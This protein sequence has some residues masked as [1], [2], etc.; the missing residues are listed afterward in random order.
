MQLGPVKVVPFA[1]GEFAHWG[2][3]LDG[4]S[5]DRTY[6]N[7]GVRASIPFW[8]VYPEVH[9]TLF[10]LNGLA[11]KVVF[12]AE[13]SYADANANFDEFPLYDPLDDTSLYEFRRR[14]FNTTLPPNIDSPKFDPRTYAIRSG[15]QG[16]VT[17]PSTEM[18]DDLLAARFGM[19]NRW[20]TKRGGPGRQHIVDWLTIDTNV[21]LFP[22]PD[23]DNFGQEL[24]LFDYDLRW[25]LGDRFTVLSDGAAD[26]FGSGLITAAGGILINRPSRWNGYI[27]VRTINGPVSSNAIIGSYSYRL[28]EKWLTSGSATFDLASVGNIGQTFSM[29]RIGESMLFSVGFNVDKSKNNVG[30]TFSIE[31][32]FLPNLRLTRDTGI[33][34]PPAGA[35]GLE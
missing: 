35:F 13:L 14:L 29:T 25:H 12:D 20:Q 6:I 21:T 30:V 11:H 2:E 19:R 32:R 18:A 7:T 3:T 16:W 31:P 33:D 27:G 28:S 1:L 17:S 4:N 8:A 22:N 5:L 23:R 9:D 26:F 24:G 15:I 34:V 10:N